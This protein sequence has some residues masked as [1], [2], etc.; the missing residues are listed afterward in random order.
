MVNDVDYKGIEFTVLK[1]ILARLKRKIIFTLMCFVM[2]ITWFI[3][4]I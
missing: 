3:L 1:T 4:F 2:K